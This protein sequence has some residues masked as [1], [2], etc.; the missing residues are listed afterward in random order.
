MQVKQDALAALPAGERNILT[1]VMVRL[2]C[3][4]SEKQVYED[5]AVVLDCGGA[6]FLQ[7]AAW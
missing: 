7:R 5:T 1:L 4:V 3:A 2:L 6:A